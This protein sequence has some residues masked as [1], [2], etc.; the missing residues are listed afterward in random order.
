MKSKTLTAAVRVLFVLAL[1]STC[2]ALA[3]ERKGA[4]FSGV[5][6]FTG[7][8]N[9]Y[10]PA[11]VK[12]GPGKCTVNGRWTFNGGGASPTFPRI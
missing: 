12:G 3:Q 5:T 8:I 6:S 9:D 4:N 1:L 7:L 10:S 11:T 2:V